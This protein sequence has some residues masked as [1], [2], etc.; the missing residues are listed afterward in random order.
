[1]NLELIVS[2]AFTLLIFSYLLGDNVL[3]RLAIYVFVGLTS[4]FTA[5]VTLENVIIPFL[6]GNFAN[7]ILFLI[8]SILVLLLLLKPIRLFTPISN[9]ALAF[10]IAV[11]SA[12]AV[13][14]AITGT[15]IPLVQS[16]ARPAS[17]GNMLDTVLI[18]VGVVT[19]LAYFQYVARRRPN[20][21]IVRGNISRVMGVIGEGFI[22][23]TL[24][25]VYGAA[26]LSSL[27]VLTGHLSNLLG[28]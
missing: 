2:F 12:V 23:I 22:M 18:F 16:T 21:E 8:A 25:A 1:M 13:L 5:I 17:N 28:S 10:L 3:Y 20:G 26:I 11:G 14:G 24:G 19:S 27:S 9:L 7:A 4:A 6:D 15:L